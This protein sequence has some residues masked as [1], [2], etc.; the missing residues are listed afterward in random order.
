MLSGQQGVTGYL[1]PEGPY[2]DPKGGTLREVVYARLRS[3]FQFQNQKMLFPI[4]RRVKYS[5]NI[6]AAP[7][8]VA[9]DQ[10]ANIFAVSTIDASYLHD[11]IGMS[12]GIKNADNEWDIS[13]HRDR[14]IPITDKELGVFAQLYDEAGTPPRRARLPALHAGALSSVLA[15]LAAYPRRLA[16]LGDDYF[17]TEMWHETMQQH[18][19]TISRRPVGDTGFVDS[20]ADWVLSGPHFSSPTRSTKPRARSAPRRAI[21]TPIDL[22]AIPDDY[23]PRTNYRPM[24]DRAEYARRTPTVSWRETGQPNAALGRTHRCRAGAGPA[25]QRAKRDH[26]THIAGEEGNGFLSANFANH[27]RLLVGTNID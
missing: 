20:P 7:Q 26:T 16:Y 13:G 1:H 8:T 18:D 4:G 24:A 2:D 11:G 15:K 5:I 22:E 27:D 3:H 9:F 21:T 6:Y 12:G 19:S 10:L 25:A 17:S 14:I 23:L